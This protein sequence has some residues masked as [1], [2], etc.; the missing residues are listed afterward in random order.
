VPRITPVQKTLNEM[1]L[2]V[3]QA[4]PYFYV[5]YLTLLLIDRA[6]RDDKRC[7]LK[8]NT[9]WEKYKKRVPYKILPHVY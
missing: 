9:Y 1:W 8:Y 4:F 7:Q 2:W 5:F 3:I 6:E